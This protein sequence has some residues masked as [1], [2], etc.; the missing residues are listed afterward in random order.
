LRDEFKIQCPAV[1]RSPTTAVDDDVSF[2]FDN[3]RSLGRVVPDF[4]GGVY[5]VFSV[6]WG[7]IGWFFCEDVMFGKLSKWDGARIQKAGITEC[8]MILEDL[9]NNRVS[10][11]EY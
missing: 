5:D 10:L 2:M 6:A 9:W 4:V 8:F 3:D 11:V 7:Y 1:M